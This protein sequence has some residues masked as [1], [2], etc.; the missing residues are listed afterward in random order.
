MCNERPDCRIG[1]DCRC[2]QT[3]VIALVEGADPGDRQDRVQT[4][5]QKA[6]AVGN[7]SRV[8]HQVLGERGDDLGTQSGIRHL[9]R[10]GR[11][12]ALILLWSRRSR[13]ALDPA[14]SFPGTD[15][16][17]NTRCQR[18]DGRMG[19]DCRRGQIDLEPLVEIADPRD[20]Q[21]GIETQIEKA[22]IC[23]DLI[24]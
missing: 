20:C 23:A 16:L 14:G 1:I 13:T 4:Q 12:H 22:V 15:K 7:V 8:E 24:D 17:R 11:L 21:N 18:R 5:V 2:R 3:D 19:I 6:R 10:L 9:D